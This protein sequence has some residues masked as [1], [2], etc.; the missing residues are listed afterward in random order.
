MLFVSSNTYLSYM[1]V[2]KSR[3]ASSI[4]V[5]C[6]IYIK[7]LQHKSHCKLNRGIGLR[8]FIAIRGTFLN[9]IFLIF[10][11]LI[12]LYLFCYSEYESIVF[13]CFPKLILIKFVPSV[14]TSIVSII[15][16][17]PTDLL[18][19]NADKNPYEK[20]A[21]LRKYA[22]GCSCSQPRLS[23]FFYSI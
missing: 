4:Y 1:T 16:N 10:M 2:V 11:F 7:K 15:C 20:I 17:H 6:N 22:D 3:N 23:T 9:Q 12:F 14:R 5:L 18:L 8:F 13:P 21:I 19:Q